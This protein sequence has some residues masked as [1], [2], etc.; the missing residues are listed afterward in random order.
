MCLREEIP[1]GSSLFDKRTPIARRLNLVFG[2]T[3]KD[4]SV[5]FTEPGYCS[6]VSN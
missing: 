3:T 5:D 2:N 6:D 4:I 1:R